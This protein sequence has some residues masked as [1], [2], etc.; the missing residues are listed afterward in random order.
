L[1]R[2]A[3]ENWSEE[4]V[5]AHKLTTLPLS[6]PNFIKI[7]DSDVGTNCSWTQKGSQGGQARD[8]PQARSA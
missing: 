2:E 5:R 3:D 7:I 4:E 1:G 8:S 6:V